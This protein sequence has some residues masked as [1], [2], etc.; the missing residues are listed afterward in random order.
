MH[1]WVG[2]PAPRANS[3]SRARRSGSS[4]AGRVSRS[5]LVSSFRRCVYALNSAGSNQPGH[6]TFLLGVHEG[7]EVLV[8]PNG[9]M[10]T[11]V[12]CAR[13]DP[14]LLL[15]VGLGARMPFD[16][17]HLISLG[18]AAAGSALVA[19]LLSPADPAGR[20]LLDS[21][22]TC[23]PRSGWTFMAV[24]DSMVQGHVIWSESPPA[25]REPLDAT[26]L[27][28]AFAVLASSLPAADEI[29]AV[30]AE[31]EPF[32]R[33]ARLTFDPSR[34]TMSGTDSDKLSK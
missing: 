3:R 1:R 33:E 6:A 19:D 8:A 9:D 21:V 34:M 28:K 31:W 14:P 26:Q 16:A 24:S 10:P 27:A 25:L 18:R 17:A 4:R 5:R 32:A 11:T 30:V 2:S 15:G 23:G 12:F 13:I 20:R 7:V 22:E 29:G